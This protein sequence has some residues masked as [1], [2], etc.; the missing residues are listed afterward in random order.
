M[1]KAR[2]FPLPAMFLPAAMVILTALLGG[3]C[4]RKETAKEAAKE[5]DVAPKQAPSVESAP[6]EPPAALTERL[7]REKFTGDLDELIKRRFI[8]VLVV[9]DRTS[10]MF[11]GVQMRGV[12]Y[13]SLR[14]FETV[15]NKKYKTG[16]APIS[17]IFLPVDRDHVAGALAE[18]RGEIVGKPMA[19]EE[20]WKKYGDFTDPIRENIKYVV[21]TGPNSP[22]LSKLEDLSGKEVYLHKLSAFYLAIE[23]LNQRFKSEGRAPVLVKEADPNLGE[24]DILEMLNA[25]LIGLTVARDL[26]ATFWSKIY[27]GIHPHPEWVVASGESTAIGVR[28]NCPKLVAE[29]NEFIKDHRE[30]TAYGNTMLNRYLKDTKWVRNSL[31]EGELKKFSEMVNL[32]RRYGDKY[33][34]PYLLVAAQAYQESR[35]EQTLHSPTGAVGVMQIKPETAAG[36][37]INIRNV[38]QV[39][40]NI[41]AG[42]KYLRFM[43]D[44]Y[45]KDEPMDQLHKGLFALA[46]YNAGPNRIASLRRK[47]KD[48]GL[49][50]NRWFNNVEL[51]A[52]REMGRETVQYVSNIYKYY[53]AYKMVTEQ[54]TKAQ[55]A[56]ESAVKK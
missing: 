13:D 55:K 27:T 14:E 49:D 53:L 37:P 21:V 50:P 23:R 51:I 9:A 46:S 20:E 30:G 29:L 47:A 4:S 3:G 42:V 26:N 35:L 56:R 12:M 18:G 19:I 41:E 33:D 22:P 11:D 45:Y 6:E 1:S 25:G 48:E 32:F 8:R 40:R 28:K 2:A 17:L 43:V 31:E 10:I 15:L 54:R 52:S 38:T 7:A 5:N 16:K 24:D 36:N 39:D 34:F 44:S